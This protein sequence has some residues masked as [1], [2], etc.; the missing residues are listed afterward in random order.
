MDLNAKL[1]VAVATGKIP[2]EYTARLP[3]GYVIRY[4]IVAPDHP[5][6]APQGEHTAMAYNFGQNVPGRRPPV[7]DREAFV[8]FDQEQTWDDFISNEVHETLHCIAEWSGWRHGDLT[9]KR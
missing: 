2:Q 9:A 6:L 5:A 4:F 8:Y 1:K 3:G 7:P